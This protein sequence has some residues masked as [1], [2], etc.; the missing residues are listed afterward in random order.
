MWETHS[1]ETTVRL[2]LSELIYD[3]SIYA[4]LHDR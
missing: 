3:F 2:I 4:I 1:V